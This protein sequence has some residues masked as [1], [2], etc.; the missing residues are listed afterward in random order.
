MAQ[1]LGDP[2]ANA[3]LTIE[4]GVTTVVEVHAQRLTT[5]WY[6]PVPLT[7]HNANVQSFTLRSRIHVFGRGG[8]A[9]CAG[10]CALAH[11]ILGSSVSKL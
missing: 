7:T 10:C 8:G 3:S 4:I 9:G 5:S 1:N 11:P 2:Y 6:L